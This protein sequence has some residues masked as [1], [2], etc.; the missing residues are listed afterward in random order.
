MWIN[1]IRQFYRAIFDRID[2]NDLEFIQKFLPLECEQKIFFAQHPADQKH[3]V[4]VA[5]MIEEKFH[6]DRFEIRCGLLHDVGRVNG[7][8]NIFGKVFCVLAEKF[9]AL[10]MTSSQK[11]MFEVYKNHAS[12]GAEK[13]RAIGLNSEADIISKHH[14]P[15]NKNDPSAL[16]ILRFADESN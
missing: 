7:D 10:I 3:A 11:N 4:N 13:L 8:L 6:G 5:R 2:E 14:D 15:E 9:P 12:I 1:R 16:K